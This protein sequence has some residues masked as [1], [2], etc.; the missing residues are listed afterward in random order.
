MA[1]A[2][3]TR[4]TATYR[5]FQEAANAGDAELIR[6]IGVVDSLVA[7]APTRRASLTRGQP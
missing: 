3:E 2:E 1:T 7:D 4:D 6:D 5:R